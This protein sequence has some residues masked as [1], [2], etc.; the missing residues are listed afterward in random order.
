MEEPLRS[1]IVY[2]SEAVFVRLS[3]GIYPDEDV[4]PRYYVVAA[5]TK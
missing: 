5:Y 3:F 1:R 2:V 4:M